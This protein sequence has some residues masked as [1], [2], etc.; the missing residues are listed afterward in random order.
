MST[1]K[2]GRFPVAH[3]F[4]KRI[5]KIE[6]AP[7]VLPA[8]SASTG[9]SWTAEERPRVSIGGAKKRFESHG[10]KRFANVQSRSDPTNGAGR[11][12]LVTRPRADA[13][14]VEASTKR[15]E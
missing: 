6:K 10:R 11:L 8:E 1:G 15:Q 5:E 13:G 7:Q 12:Y 9:A 4:R 14:S 3:R 2:L